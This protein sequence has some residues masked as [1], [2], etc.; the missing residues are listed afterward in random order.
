METNEQEFSPCSVTPDAF[1]TPSECP[2][3]ESNKDL[4]LSTIKKL[5]QGY[6]LD[7]KLPFKNHLRTF[8]KQS[9]K[10]QKESKFWEFFE[11]N[12]IKLKKSLQLQNPP[13]II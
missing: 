3:T 1:S 7:E 8:Y 10:E 4:I 6:Q 12:S 5:A 13:W 11:M 2:A 9:N